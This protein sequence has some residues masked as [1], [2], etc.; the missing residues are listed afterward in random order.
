LISSSEKFN[1]VLGCDCAKVDRRTLGAAA[2]RH[3][4]DNLVNERI[5]Y[6]AGRGD[7]Q[8]A[9]GLSGPR[10]S[11]LCGVPRGAKSM[12]PGDNFKATATSR[13][14][15]T[16]D[17]TD[18]RLPQRCSRSRNRTKRHGDKHGQSQMDH[19]GSKNKVIENLHPI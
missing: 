16:R 11:T 7:Q 9:T 4:S 14:H 18:S 19:M 1:P 2:R 6:S 10:H 17:G 13:E 8:L 15:A 12:S 5:E 3:R